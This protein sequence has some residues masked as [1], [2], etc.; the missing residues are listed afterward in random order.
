MK[1]L[2]IVIQFV[3]TAFLLM[4][5]LP[6][7]MGWGQANSQWNTMGGS[8]PGRSCVSKDSGGSGPPEGSLADHP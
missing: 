4:A 8:N 5:A 2:C 1:K 6:P 7:S 3:L